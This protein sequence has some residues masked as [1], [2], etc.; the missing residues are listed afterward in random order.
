MYL[1]VANS[2]K[3]RDLT[4]DDFLKHSYVRCFN[5]RAVK[6]IKSQSQDQNVLFIWLAGLADHRRARLR[7]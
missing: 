1:L 6:T 7:S 2:R 4:L 5:G 3:G